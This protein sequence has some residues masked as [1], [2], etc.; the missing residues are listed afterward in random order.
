M[1]GPDRFGRITAEAAVPEQVIAYVGAVAGSR[2]KLFGACVGYLSEEQRV[3]I[4]YPL[5]D[6]TDEG[7][8]ASAVAE[9]LRCPGP[10]RI[11]VIGP[12]RP[13]QA[14]ARAVSSEDRYHLLAVPP[15]APG[16]KL[17]NLLRRAERELAVEAGRVLTQ[18]H[19]RLVGRYL[20]ER[21]LAAGTRRIFGRLSDYIQASDTSLIVSARRADGRLAAF[22]VGEY[23]SLHTAFFMFCFRD[24]QA[25]VP[26]SADRLLKALLDEAGRRGQIC[27]NLGL[28]V[29]AGI[30]HFKAKWGAGR[31]LPYVETH[32]DVSAPG[33]FGR[34][35][36]MR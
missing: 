16:Q 12:A 13:P 18:A 21:P 8:M 2:P 17:G 30:G 14:P 3:L 1:I 10:D 11:T 7:A 32:W 20:T 9:L 4:G 25:A 23:G 19:I 22:A 5:H 15:V 27:M 34:L 35:F 6:P 29:N 36:K 26:G 33:L 28:G 24:P 31:F